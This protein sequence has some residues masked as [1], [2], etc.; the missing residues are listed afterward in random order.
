MNCQNAPCVKVCPVGASY[1]NEEGIVLIDNK[2]CI[3]CR[4]CMAACPYGARYFNWEE[5][6]QASNNVTGQSTPEFANT[7]IR[8]TVEKCDFCAHLARDGTLPPC[9]SACPTQAI[10]FGDFAEDAVSNA[11]ETIPFLET[12]E[13]KFGY[14]YKEEL[15]TGPRV[16]YLP[17][18]R[19]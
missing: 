9:V 8:G 7:H 16:F 6:K 18:R 15:G 3:G 13:Q 19:D 2:L 5:P 11:E 4:F 10:Y 12:L 1:Y 14:R 17:P